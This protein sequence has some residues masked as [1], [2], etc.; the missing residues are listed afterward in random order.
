MTRSFRALP[1]LALAGLLAACGGQEHDAEAQPARTTSSAGLPNGTVE[2]GEQAANVKSAAT[3][4]TCID[5]HGA[6]GNV[7][8]DP[9]YPKIG[10]QFRDY[11][12]HSLQAYRDGDREH[13]LM[14][15]QAADLSDQQI[16]D[17]AA[18]FAAQPSQLRDLHGAHDR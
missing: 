17:L 18:Y 7:P 8:I 12:A 6:A 4:Q 1:A 5:C 14:S 13:A 9:T 3:G 2:A 11:L 10:G 15:Q 16:A